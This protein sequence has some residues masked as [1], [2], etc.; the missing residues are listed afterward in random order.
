M[1]G[2]W[3]SKP[4][5]TFDEI[6]GFGSKVL[7]RISTQYLDSRLDRLNKITK[8]LIYD[9]LPTK[10]QEENLLNTKQNYQLRLVFRWYLSFRKEESGIKNTN[11]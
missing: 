11:R 5:N 1:I 8:N 10:I 4:K 6:K 9:G 7:W 2:I 3:L